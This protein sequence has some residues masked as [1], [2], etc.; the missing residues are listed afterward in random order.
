VN[1]VPVEL[2]VCRYGEE[3]AKEL[4]DVA[5]GGVIVEY[6]KAPDQLRYAARSEAGVT[7]PGG[8]QARMNK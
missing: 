1:A 7:S 6:T 2:I 4:G 8:N 5:V 3:A